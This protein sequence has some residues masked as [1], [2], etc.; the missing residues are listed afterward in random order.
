MNEVSEEKKHNLLIKTRQ[1]MEL[2]GVS[3]VSNFDEEEIVVQI[4]SL[5]MSIE[6]ENLR[7][8][9]FNSESGE[10]NLVGLINGLFYYSKKPEKKKK[11]ITNLFK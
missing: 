6:G 10:L 7:I 9:K 4:G 2:T 5:S 3:D 8:E 11:S 1:R